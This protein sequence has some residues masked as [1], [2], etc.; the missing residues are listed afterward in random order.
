MHQTYKLFSKLSNNALMQLNEKEV[1]ETYK[2]TQ[3]PDILATYYCMYMNSVVF[4]HNK[5]NLK[6]E[7]QTA[8]IALECLD[9]CLLN[10]DGHST[11][12]TYFN[13]GLRLRLLSQKQYEMG[14][15]RNCG[16]TV[17]IDTIDVKYSQKE[18]EQIKFD[19]VLNN[20]NLTQDQLAY[21][22]YYLNNDNA[23]D[24]E[25]CKMFKINRNKLNIIKLSL[26]NKL[27]YLY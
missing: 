4:W 27:A 19:D 15:K 14:K 17:D 20:S 6:D 22:S 12:K 9:Y 8:S 1:C 13:N 2:K 25:F 21:C 18:F 5:Y 3:R 11:F 7:S 10:F 16:L 26:K 23:S 24:T